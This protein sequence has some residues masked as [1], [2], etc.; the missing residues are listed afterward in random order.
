MKK[1]PNKCFP[2][3][4]LIVNQFTILVSKQLN[5]QNIQNMQK[6]RVETM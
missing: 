3:L 4:Q 5:L 6:D 2:P 1:A